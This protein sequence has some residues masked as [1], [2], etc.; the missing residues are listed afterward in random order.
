MFDG[1]VVQAA[2]GTR[3]VDADQIGSIC[4]SHVR[5]TLSTEQAEDLPL[6]AGSTLVDIKPA[7]SMSDRLG[8]MF[9]RGKR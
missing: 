6:P 2:S 1:T 5:T 9:G 8:R 4:T 7:R 3:F